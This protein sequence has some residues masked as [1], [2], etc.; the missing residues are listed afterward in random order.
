[1]VKR[2]RETL[3]KYGPVFDDVIEILYRTDPMGIAWDNPV[4]G[5]EYGKEVRDIVARLPDARSGR[6]VAQIGQDVFHRWFGIDGRGERWDEIG[7][8]IWQAWQRRQAETLRTGVGEE[9]TR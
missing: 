2:R 6:D 8:L 5:E 3:P 9:Q 7:E 1:M 4:K